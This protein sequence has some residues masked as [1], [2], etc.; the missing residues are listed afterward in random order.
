MPSMREI[1]TGKLDRLKNAHDL[2]PSEA[3]EILVEMSAL[4]GNIN[5]EVKNRQ[6]N[7]NKKLIEMIERPKMSVAKAK[8]LVMDTDEWRDLETAKGY[9]EAMFEA[10]RGLKYFLRAKSDE[11]NESYNS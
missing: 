5:N 1:I 11:Y 6:D 10:I 8:I 7:F 2:Q 9:K 4:I 3:S